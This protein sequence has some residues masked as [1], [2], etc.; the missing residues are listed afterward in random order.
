[1][2]AQM[3]FPR[4]STLVF[5]L[6]LLFGAIPVQAQETGGWKT[7]AV[8]AVMDYRASVLADTAAKFDRCRVEQQLGAP[9]VDSAASAD[10]YRL[11]LGP[12]RSDHT[13]HVVLVDSIT[14][15]QSG[16]KVYARIVQ[17]EWQH[18][19]RF[20]LEPL[21]GRPEV[22]WVREMWSSAGVQFYPRRPTP[23]PRQ[24]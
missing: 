7:S 19:E 20:T 11:M 24:D 8:Q 14:G 4:V 6:A 3:T 17:G 18:D 5:P 21:R 1:M 13:Q 16:A 22:L 10:L 12:C 23:A 2:R 9:A 15:D